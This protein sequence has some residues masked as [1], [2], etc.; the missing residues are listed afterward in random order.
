MELED[1]QSEFLKR[2]SRFSLEKHRN[3]VTFR[4]MDKVRA[5]VTV[6]LRVTASVGVRVT[7]TV[8]VMVKVTN[9]QV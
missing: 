9:L 6:R 5:T 8:R 1:H 3:R 4:V 7:I 2:R